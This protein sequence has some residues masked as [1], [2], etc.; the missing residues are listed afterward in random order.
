MKIRI[1]LALIAIY[2]AWGSTY[3]A[4]RF[5]VETLPP[6][7]MASTRFLIS[8]AILI[9][10]R[11]LAGDAPPRRTEWRSTV[12]VGL[13]LLVGGNGGVSWAE[14]YVP[15]GIAALIVG[16]TPLWIVLLDAFRPGGQKPSP[17]V[18][19]G[20]LIGFLGIVVLVAPTD[21]RDLLHRL[22]PLGT[23]VL[24]LAA[25]SWAI[26]SLIGRDAP[27]PSSALMATAWEMLFGGL[28]LLLLGSLTRE[29]GRLNLQGASPKSIYGLVYLIVVG[30]LIGFTCY[31]WLLRVAP[32]S[33]AS[34]YAYVNP[35]IAVILGNL[36]ADEPLTPRILI[37][38][39][40][41]LGSV[42]F[43]RMKQSKAMS[44]K[45]AESAVFIQGE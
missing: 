11:Q 12:L 38:T 35:L 43:V 40:I 23:L 37:A 36:L 14:Q 27:L 44:R 8:G 28:G 41:I 17:W 26:G 18:L 4:I 39:P 30:S 1:W 13:F 3:L 33:L 9:L 7:L 16:S 22:H 42:A 21:P 15:S 24:I 31:T 25:L 29:W 5:A 45:G 32:I 6:F 19:V 10:W 34:T 2:L 20:I